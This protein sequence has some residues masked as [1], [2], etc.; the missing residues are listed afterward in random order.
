MNLFFFVSLNFFQLALSFVFSFLSSGIAGTSVSHTSGGLLKSDAGD[1]LVMVNNAVTEVIAGPDLYFE[2]TCVAETPRNYD[3][4]FQ[5]QQE[6]Q[7]DL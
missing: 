5:L 4:F 2:A 6:K 1:W 3:F 7:N